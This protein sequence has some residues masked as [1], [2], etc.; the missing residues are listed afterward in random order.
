LGLEHSDI[1]LLSSGVCE[2]YHPSLADQCV[3]KAADYDNDDLKSSQDDLDGG[4]K[5]AKG[6]LKLNGSLGNT[7]LGGAGLVY[8]ICHR[9]TD[10][11]VITVRT[12]R[13]TVGIDGGDNDLSIA[14]E[15]K[16]VLLRR[17]VVPFAPSRHWSSSLEYL[18]L[19][20]RAL[21]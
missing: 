12:A 6:H 7:R 10:Q 13:F 9:R 11:F 14:T 21:L 2:G 4:V 5:N 18:E 20:A 8:R 15:V 19:A 16:L 1:G 3:P 17:A